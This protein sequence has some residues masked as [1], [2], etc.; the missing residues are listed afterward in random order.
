MSNKKSFF[1]HAM[2]YWLGRM[3]ARSL[4]I[5]LLPI[6]TTYLSPTDYG[7]LSILGIII[8]VAALVLCFQL[9]V[10]IYKFWV[11]EETEQGRHQVLGSAMLVTMVAPMLILLPVYIW[12]DYFSSLL[13]IESHA[14]L[15]R[16]ALVEGQLGM[17]IIVIMTEMRIRDESLRFSLWEMS[18]RVGIGLLSILLIAGFGLGIWGIFIAHVV[19]FGGITLWL[20]PPFLRRVGLCFDQ[21]ITKKMFQYALPLVPSAVAMA[22]VHSADRFFLQRM[23]GLEATG[24][25]EIGY[26]FGMLVNILVFGPFLLIWQPKRFTIANED[27]AGEKYGQIFTYLLVL[28]SFVAMALS[29]LAKEIV[30]IMT[31]PAYRESYTIVALVAWSYVFFALSSVVSVGL[32][33][34]NKTAT[35]AWIVFFTFIVNILG[36]ILLIPHYGAYGAAFATLASFFVLFVCNLFYSNRYIAIEFE[37]KK[38]FLLSGLVL[39]GLTV[40]SVVITGNLFTDIALKGV[41]LICFLCALYF[42]RFFDS[43]RLPERAA[44]LWCSVYGKGRG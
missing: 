6:F 27:G 30:Q 16:L 44:Y 8:D 26:K 41:V 10:A 2:I 17:I 34:H 11:K 32:F 39:V 29:G 7:E 18:Q 35:S 22:A 15:L 12:A 43:L 4:Q 36:N 19:V 14:N 25:Y 9:P 31:A 21:E 42:L 20:L 3:A 1:H 38:I 5:I 40:M 24:L 13:G 23:V 28:T 37:L 33:V